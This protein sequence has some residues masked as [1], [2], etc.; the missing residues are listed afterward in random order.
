MGIGTLIIFIAVIIIAAI[1]AAVL[2]TTGGALQSRA[3]T[4]GRQT[5]EEIASGVKIFSVIGSDAVNDSAIEDID[6]L[7][8][9]NPGAMPIKW[10]TT[11]ITF[12]TVDYSMDMTYSGANVTGSANTYRIEY[13]QQGPDYKEGYIN[14]GD[15][16][17]VYIE[18]NQSIEE[19]EIVRM[20]I[21]PATGLST[22]VRFVTPSAM[23]T[24]RVF[25][26][27]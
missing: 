15:I 27:P 10:D 4:T 19:K 2:I 20:E 26:F 17:R 8:R 1:A 7:I 24:S 13:L 21:I 23:T 25:L 12:D 5:E 3:L 22:M 11:L 9:L 18:L 14:Q 16:V 6:L